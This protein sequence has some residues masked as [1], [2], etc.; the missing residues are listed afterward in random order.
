MTTI[1]PEIERLKGCPFCGS[2]PK[3]IEDRNYRT[4]EPNGEWYVICHRCDVML[5]FDPSEEAAAKRW[6]TRSTIDRLTLPA[7][8][9]ER[10]RREVLEDAL[11]GYDSLTKSLPSA[12]PPDLSSEWRQGLSA[13]SHPR[14]KGGHERDRGMPLVPC[15]GAA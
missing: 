13:P 10:A 1:R 4:N 11:G 8:E 6:N 9:G 15:A 12:R 2:D 7:A 5:D 3:M 14:R